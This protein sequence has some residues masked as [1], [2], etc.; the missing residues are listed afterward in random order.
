MKLSEKILTLRKQ[1]GLS[2]EALAEKLNVSRQAVSRWEVG[3]A[4]PDASNVL[5][6]S[7][8]FGVTADYLLNE[9]YNSDQDVPAVIHTQTTANK[10]TKNIIALC[11]SAFGLFGN[12]VFY[13]LSRFIEVHIPHII[14]ENNGKRI[15][16]W[17]SDLKGHSYKYFIW[18]YNLE[19][20]TLLFWGLVLTGLIYT[21]THNDKIRKVFKNCKEK[22]K[23]HSKTPKKNAIFKPDAK[24]EQS[25]E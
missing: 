2:Q 7:K 3:S 11:V 15:E 10:K 23:K 24:T 16:H 18:E 1:N 12:F 8:L 5:Q 13:L 20:L 19:F 9:D 25:E 21:A 14:Y 17:I 22:V 4:L 6:L